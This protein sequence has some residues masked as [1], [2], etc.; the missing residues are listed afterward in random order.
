MK[1]TA[2]VTIL[3]I[4]IKF[5]MA[6]QENKIVQTNPKRFEYY[7]NGAFGFY[8]P[9][10]T[11]SAV[12]SRGNISTFQFQA[13]DKDNFFSRLCFDQYNVG[14][15]DNIN[16]N[17]LNT[18]IKDKVQTTYIGVDIGYTF[19]LGE[20]L[21]PFTYIGAGFTSIDVPVVN[22]NNLQNNLRI[23]TSTKSFLGLRGG[24]GAEY[25]F[26]KFF[27]L[28]LDAQY[29]SIPFKTDLSNKQLNGV[30][31]QIGFKTPLQ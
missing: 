5:S 9:L 2:L 7:F 30:S 29:L 25:E 22:Y 13:N 24:I 1:Q 4:T 23:V 14:Y 27:I 17:G 31:I 10:N 26:N 28:Y 18:Y 21:S 19:H 16:I 11:A 15:E 12:A 20:K 8:F 6:Q 3:L